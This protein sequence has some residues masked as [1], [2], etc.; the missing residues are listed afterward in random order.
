M[1]STLEEIRKKLQQAQ[2]DRNADAVSQI[3]PTEKKK[4]LK[5]L[6]EFFVRLKSSE[7][8]GVNKSV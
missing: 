4:R 1:A 5:R 8:E 7:D 3:D 6:K 2:Q